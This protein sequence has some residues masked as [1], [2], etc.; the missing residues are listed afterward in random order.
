M[1][2]GNINEPGANFSIG[3]FSFPGPRGNLLKQNLFTVN[4]PSPRSSIP[5]V[6]DWV[7]P[8]VVLE[9]R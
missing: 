5:I 9:V 7:P 4:Y 1:C 6:I 3:Y 8:L 2:D